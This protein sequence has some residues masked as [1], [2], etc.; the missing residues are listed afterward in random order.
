MNVLG[1]SDGMSCGQIALAEPGCFPDKYYASEADKFAIRQTMGVFPGTIRLGDVTKADVSQPD[2][3]DLLIG[4]S[5]CPP[6][7]IRRK[8][9]GHGY[10]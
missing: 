3:I 1:L 8:T 7:F 6:V 2:K 10:N 4:G 9:G 5:P